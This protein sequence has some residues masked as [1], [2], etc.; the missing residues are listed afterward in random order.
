MTMTNVLF[1]KRYGSAEY[2]S[3]IST[4][5][6]NALLVGAIIG[7]IS[8]G[9]VTDRVGRKSAIVLTTM[10]LTLGAIFATAAYPVGGNLSAL[11]W[12]LT[13]E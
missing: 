5:V 3:A 7:Q 12:W 2:T 4:R 1:G 11:W 6:S 8:M 9:I 13:G 10:I